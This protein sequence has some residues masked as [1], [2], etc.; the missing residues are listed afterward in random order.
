MDFYFVQQ[1]DN[2]RLV[3]ALDPRRRREQGAMVAAVA[4]LLVLSLAYA[5]QRFEMVRLGYQMEA[6]RQ[7]QTSLRQ[8]NRELELQQAALASPNRIYG[9]AQAKLGM[10]SAAPGQILALDVAPGGIGTAPVMA[11]ANVTGP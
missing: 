9:L 6:A 3:R 8:W 10:Q 7:E 1:I 2:S 5:W 4:L 11:A